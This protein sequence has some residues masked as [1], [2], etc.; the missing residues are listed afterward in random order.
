MSSD[1]KTVPAFSRELIDAMSPIEY[2]VAEILE[3]EGRIKII[4]SP[5]VA[6]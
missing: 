1:V 6:S 2:K 5:G 3:S 4:G